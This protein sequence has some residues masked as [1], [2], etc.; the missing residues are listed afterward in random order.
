MKNIDK[1]IHWKLF[2]ITLLVVVIVLSFPIWKQLSIDD[3][4]ATA[5]SYN[6]VQ[7]THLD[8]KEYPKSLMFPVN[9]KYALENLK[10]TKIKII[11]DTK[12]IEEYTLLLKISKTSSLDYHCLNVA[13][14]QN[15][16]PLEKYYFTEDTNN[17]YFALA[18]DSIIAETKNYD[19]LMWM[20]EK[21]GNEMQGKTLNYSF[22]LQKG[23][24]I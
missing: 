10:K 12:I 7:Y 16:L 2:E 19:F 20:D 1:L 24:A 13:I 4:L 14:N 9:N 21:T 8:I 5:A 18:K 15:A 11:N 6:N 3:S 17:Y 23:V 22:E